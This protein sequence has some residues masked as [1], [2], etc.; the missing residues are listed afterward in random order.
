MSAVS[1]KTLLINRRNLSE[2][3]FQ[4]EETDIDSL[5][6]NSVLFAIDRVSIT[7]NNITY[8]VLGDRMKYWHFFPAD[9]DWGKLPVWGFA[10]VVASNLQDIAVGERFYGYF[11]LASHLLVHPAKLSDFGFMDGAPHRTELPRIYN[12]YSRC[13]NDAIYRME[14]ENLQALLR[15]L[16]T[17]S[18]LLDDYLAESDFNGAATILVSSASS[19]TSLGLAFMLKRNRS[20]RRTYRIIG[21]TSPGNVEFTESSGLYDSVVTYDMVPTL[22]NSES[23]AFADMAGNQSL[24]SQLHNHYDKK[25][26]LSCQIGLA[27]WQDFGSPSEMPGAKPAWFFAPDQAVKRNKEWGQQQFQTRLGEAWHE[28]TAIADSWLKTK[29]HSTDEA[30][31]NIYLATLSGN[32]SPT[33]GHII[34]F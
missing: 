2:F 6:E 12:Y 8:A 18:F 3:K 9:D 21:L 14:T 5:P 16:F 29:E 33:T 32:A 24:T 31:Q 34:R 10:N 22:D 23:A 7:A 11:P 20:A 19:K 28:F 4:Q 27:H 30:I 13:S 15:P 25:M 26:L 1:S 17:T